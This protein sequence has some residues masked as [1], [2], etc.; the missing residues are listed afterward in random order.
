MCRARCYK[1]TRNVAFTRAIAYHDSEDDPIASAAGTFML[2]TKPGV[3][4]EPGPG[5]R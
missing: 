4:T 2:H 5:T 1:L 3:K